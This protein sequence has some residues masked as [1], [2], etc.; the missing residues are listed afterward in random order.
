MTQWNAEGMKITK[1]ADVLLKYR[2]T[3]SPIFQDSDT[4][5]TNI[6]GEKS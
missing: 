3:D 1:I 2:S 4:A 6:E 5:L